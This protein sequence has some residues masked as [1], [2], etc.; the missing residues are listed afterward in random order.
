MGSSDTSD[1]SKMQRGHWFATTHWSL[2]LAA[3]YDSSTQAREALEQLC[4]VYWSPLYAYV[5]SRGYSPEDAQDLTQEFFL[6]FLDKKYFKMADSQRGKFRTFLLTALKNFLVN[7]WKK[8]QAAKRGAGKIISWDPQA[9]EEHYAAEAIEQA[10]PERIFDRRWAETL[11]D[12]VRSRLRD[13]YTS[14]G[15][16]ALFER[17]KGVLEADQEP[18]SYPEWSREL[19]MTEGA[20]KVAVHRLRHRYHEMLRAEVAHTVES[21]SEVEEELRYLL[22]VLRN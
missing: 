5:R 11:L 21:R 4:L 10:S 12:R 3:G 19:G 18:P 7:E 13:E 17:L 15:K 22:Q 2:V 1:D 14:F 8:G 6:R 16:L 9:A 20:L